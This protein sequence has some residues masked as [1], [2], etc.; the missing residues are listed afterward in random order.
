MQNELELQIKTNANDTDQVLQ[1]LISTLQKV[2]TTMNGLLTKT[3]RSNST[4]GL[5]SSVDSLTQKANKLN[6]A[7]NLTSAF[8]AAE[9][10]FRKLYSAIGE[11]IDYSENLNLF[12]VAMDDLT[13]K[14]MKFQNTL[15]EA[16]GTNKS[17]TLYY[18]GIFQSMAKSMGVTNDDAYKLSEGLTKIGFDLASLYNLSDTSAMKKLRAGL[19][20]QTEPLR[21][22][23]MDITENSLKPYLQKLNI[24]DDSGEII[25]VRNLNYAEK[26][27]LRYIAIVDQA[28]VS[29]GDF[30]NTIEAPANQ[31]KILTQQASEAGRALGNLFVG[32]LAKILPYANAVIMVIKE[33][34]NAIAGVLG[35]EISDYNSSIA[36]VEDA[37]SNIDDYTSGASDGLDSANKSAKKL[38]QTLTSMNFDEI[39]SISTPTSTSSSGSSG[40]GSGID[41]S[42][43]PRLLAALGDYENGMEKVRM[44]ANQIRDAI[45]E[46]LGFTYDAEEGLWKF[47]D[48]L[49]PIKVILGSIA[50]LIAGKL[51][52]A[53]KS[54]TTAFGNS[55]LGKAVSWLLSP[56][57]TLITYFKAARTNGLSLTKSLSSSITT[58]GKY[59]TVL[60][61]VKVGA[62]GVIGAIVSLTG[63]SK[64]MESVATK[65]WTLGNSL[66]T[67]AAGI[68]SVASGAA[69]GTA[70]M[71]G[72]GTAVGA[73][74]GGVA[75]LSV[76]LNS[77]LSVEE[78]QKAYDRLFD[79]QG[80]SI[81]YVKQ[82]LDDAV[83]SMVT[84]AEK[85]IELGNSY[86]Q[87]KTN[88]ENAKAT[89]DELHQTLASNNYQLTSD[90]L[91]TLNTSYDTW[92]Q[93]VISAGETQKNIIIQNVEKLQEEGR[94]SKETADAI[95]A[96]ET[97]KQAAL[98]SSTEGYKTAM[99]QLDTQLANGKI[100]QEEY[101]KK[102]A[103]L[104]EKYGTTSSSVADLDTTYKIWKQR[105][106]EGINLKDTETLK[107]LV[108]QLGEEYEGNKEKLETSYQKTKKATE[109]SISDYEKLRA[110]YQK[111]SVEYN[112][113]TSKIEKLQTTLE[114]SAKS[115]EESMST[116][117][118]NYKGVLA[119]IYTEISTAGGKTDKDITKVKTSVEKTLKTIGK[120]V[121]MTGTG[122][123]IFD[124]FLNDLVTNE[125]PFLGKLKSGFQQYG[126]QASTAFYEKVGLTKAQKQK[127]YNEYDDAAKNGAL[128]GY[129]DAIT[130]KEGSSS[131]NAAGQHFG[132]KTLEGAKSSLKIN[133]PSKELKTIGQYT[134]AGYIKG[135]ES[136]DTELMAK[137]NDLLEKVK[138]KFSNTKLSFNINTSVE[139]S[140]NSI[141]SKLQSFCDK[142]RTAIN[143]LV[144]NMQSTMNGISINGKGKVTYT[145]MP[146]LAV[147][148]FS[149][150][151]FPEDGLF[152]ANHSE[153]VGKFANGKTAVANNEQILQGITAGVYNAVRDALQSVPQGGGVAEIIVRTDESTIVKT[154]IKGINGETTR[155][156]EC[157]I[158]VM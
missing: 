106:D 17:N 22:V 16:F 107:S 140:F 156:G 26:M 144:R 133:S 84:H 19:A 148:K 42:I 60:S 81:S 88:A 150:G 15:N 112:D 103:E 121:D 122:K 124:S 32:A 77:Y 111:G 91:N 11:S 80:V 113:Y 46:W 136:K 128:K 119:T 75:G 158:K 100:T 93:N 118:G 78:K 23:G 116:L 20:G 97:E 9:N 137:I 41:S 39:H 44:K 105:F 147:P 99:S 51:L 8:K 92:A 64:A 33:V 10:G 34:A 123:E 155:T 143:N 82:S 58:W 153:L 76:A 68:G 129:T 98:I 139:H 72:L 69:I 50:A 157:P 28:K 59:A 135:I 87:S 108:K 96:A 1:K 35:I 89:I 40:S 56:F 126:I 79:G 127:V 5:E 130:G 38:K 25:S 4:K 90:Q 65:G 31:L 138:N 83:G 53:V 18:Q 7:F 149:K 54:L 132:K 125:N 141:L 21:T 134:I 24:T 117:A 52:R 55:G 151:G 49:T 86:E 95:I 109:N 3:S 114:E 110:N 85:V 115:H 13:E 71:P 142:W 48:G 73:V 101:N 63:M 29:Q 152:Y 27:I 6:N 14:G 43:D 131:L 74:A 2:D 61:K 94:I 120:D 45:M 104:G 12:N 47:N 70:I 145:S 67:A 66:G 37:W 30:A 102:V 154:A 36:S 146:Y 57:S 62:V